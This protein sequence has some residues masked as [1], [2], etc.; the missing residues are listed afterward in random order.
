MES[1][2]SVNTNSRSSISSSLLNNFDSINGRS[3]ENPVTQI[4]IVNEDDERTDN[5][6]TNESTETVTSNINGK[7]RTKVSTV[8]PNAISVAR[9]SNGTLKIV[10]PT[11][12]PR[13]GND[14]NN[15][16]EINNDQ[17]RGKR[18]NTILEF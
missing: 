11:K 4:G 9:D 6:I 10:Y 13:Y 12:I 16:D 18:G 8:D 14:D 15:S 7:T 2:S 17:H 3:L 5:P 1:K